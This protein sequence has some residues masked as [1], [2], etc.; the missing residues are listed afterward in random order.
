MHFHVKE[1]RVQFT[2]CEPLAFTRGRTGDRLR[3]AFGKALKALGPEPYQ[4]LFRRAHDRLVAG[5]SDPPRPFVFRIAGLDGR[6]FQ[7]GGRF[8][9]PLYLFDPAPQMQQWCTA[10]VRALFGSC[11]AVTGVSVAQR[12]LSLDTG[13]GTIARVQVDFV[14]PTELKERG[15]V[16]CNP[17]FRV[18]F[19]RA[20]DRIRSLSLLYGYGLPEMDLDELGRRAAT[21]RLTEA[22]LHRTRI[23][24]RSS[25]NGQMYSVGGITGWGLYEGDL[26]EFLP[27][28]RVAEWTG[29]GRHTA[30]GNGE[31]CI[32]AQ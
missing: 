16:A 32:T 18:L 22:A 26:A 19:A 4:K 25:S 23:M 10:A 8:E 30:W 17:E 7:P 3:G 27:W 29:V 15:Q 21:V 31:I 5:M 2:A 9:I 1:M 24:R 11:A 14:T 13:S 20:R 6:T 12:E 28:L